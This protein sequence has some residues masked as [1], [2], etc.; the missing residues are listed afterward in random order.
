MRYIYIYI[1]IYILRVTHI[2]SIYVGGYGHNYEDLYEKCTY[3]MSIYRG[4]K[5]TT[6]GVHTSL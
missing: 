3:K 5:T 2:R 4:R 6:Q 1:Y